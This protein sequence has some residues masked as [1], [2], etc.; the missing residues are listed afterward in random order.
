MKRAVGRQPASP[1]LA[2][3]SIVVVPFR[4][5]NKVSQNRSVPRYSIAALFALGMGTIAAAPVLIETATLSTPRAG[6]QATLMSDGRVLLTGGCS[7]AGCSDVQKSAELYDPATRKFSTVQS[8]GEAR[9]SHLA[10]G[11]PDGRI[12]VAGG[13]T[14][15]G[16]T[17]SIEL[18]DPSIGAFAPGP[19]MSVARMDGT[20]TS[21]DSGDV[22]LVGGSSQTNR[23]TASVDRYSPVS[24]KV[25]AVGALR[26]ARAHHAAVRMSD[27]R[28]LVMGGL[29]SRNTA[30]AS[31]EIYDP[32]AGTFT[33]TGSLRQ[34]RCKHAAALLRDGRVMVL[35][36]SSDCDERQKLATTE[37]FD[38]ATGLF[39]QGPALIDPR[40]KVANAAV[41]M[42]DGAVLIAG[43]SA[44]IEVWT[45][46]AASFKKVQG[47][48]GTAL[49]FGTVTA[50]QNRQVLVAGGYD[51]RITPTARSWLL[52]SP[53]ARRTSLH[54]SR[55]PLIAPVRA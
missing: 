41:V 46:G 28:V 29:V 1:G 22:L 4:R 11:L 24:G 39:S 47:V 40:Y 6:H 26:T 13:W 31:A 35:A 14:G 8:M 9:V 3:A 16:A 45:P 19:G 23:P 37:I 52:R 50:L 12:L 54:H 27:G 21:L 15:S 42:D 43:G 33:P 25:V 18:F 20:A 34:P 38:P 49:A 53:V 10:A 32:R 36:G 51:S 5:R 30:T 17:A 48:P 7:G 44:D 2:R 55:P